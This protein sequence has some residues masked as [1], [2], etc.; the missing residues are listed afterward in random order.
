MVKSF[1]IKLRALWSEI[2][3]AHFFFS[4][5]YSLLYRIT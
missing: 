5:F 4:N 3:N 1:V 2:Y